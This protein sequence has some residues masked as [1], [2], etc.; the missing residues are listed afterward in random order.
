MNIPARNTHSQESGW[1]NLLKNRLA[2]TLALV[3]A[4]DHTDFGVMTYD[5]GISIYVRNESL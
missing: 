2:S 1:R 5:L 3:R 4:M